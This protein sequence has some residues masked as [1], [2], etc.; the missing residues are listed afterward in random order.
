MRKIGFIKV[1]AQNLLIYKKNWISSVFLMVLEPILYL[2]V[3]GYGIGKYINEINGQSYLEFFFTGYLS[4]AIA[5]VSLLDSYV[6]QHARMYDEKIYSTWLATPLS[7]LDIFLGETVWSAFKGMLAALVTCIVGF[8]F[9]IQFSILILPLLLIL[10]FIAYMF[11]CLGSLIAMS[12]IKN[13]S[14][15]VHFLV[16]LVATLLIAGALFPVQSLSLPIMIF[17]YLMPLTHAVQLS[18]SFLIGQFDYFMIVHMAYILI[19][20]YVMFRISF[21]FFKAK[22]LG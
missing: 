22:V 11:S 6:T 1:T 9:G 15:G 19:S 7:K 4:L 21:K 5:I 17:S 12:D 14:Y 2:S 3:F 18:H 20:S 10:F 8:I 13:R 16:L